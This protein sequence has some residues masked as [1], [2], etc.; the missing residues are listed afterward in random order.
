M[1]YVA[2][3]AF[4]PQHVSC[5]NFDVE[6][7]KGFLL[8]SFISPGRPTSTDPGIFCEMMDIYE[9]MESSFRPNRHHD[10][11]TWNI[12][13]HRQRNEDEGRRYT[14]KA[15]CEMIDNKHY[16]KKQNGDKTKN[17]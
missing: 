4:T 15:L 6:W 9:K 10:Y 3:R 7:P 16:L 14:F 17:N 2:S 5:H 1:L 13:K 8:T 12:E 11:K